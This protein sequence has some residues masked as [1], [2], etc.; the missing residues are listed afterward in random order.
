MLI[1]IVTIEHLQAQ[2]CSC[3]HYRN[4]RHLEK[5]LRST[6]NYVSLSISTL[7]QDLDDEDDSA[8]SSHLGDLNGD[9]SNSDDES[10][11]D[12]KNAPDVWEDVVIEDA[13]PD[14]IPAELGLPAFVDYPHG[15]GFP[16]NVDDMHV[17]PN[18]Q[19][20]ETLYNNTQLSTFH[21]TFAPDNIINKFI[22]ATNAHGAFRSPVTWKEIDVKEFHAFL[23]CIIYLGIFKY[24][25][26]KLLAW[27]TDQGSAVLRALMP[28]TM[29][30]QILSNW[31][32]K[33]FTMLSKAQ[34]NQLIPEDPFWAVTDFSEDINESF[35]SNWNPAQCLDIDEQC[36]PWKGRHKCRCFSPKKPEKW[37]FK[38]YA[39]NCS[40]SGYIVHFKIYRGKGE[41][42]PEGVS[43]TAYPIHALLEPPKFHHRGHVL[44]TD[45]C[46]TSL[47]SVKICGERG[48]HSVDTIKANRKGLPLV[49]KKVSGVRT[50]KMVRGETRTR[51][52]TSGGRELF[53]TIWQAASLFDYCNQPQLQVVSL[54]LI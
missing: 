36:C 15:Y 41:V 38:M 39:L 34:M 17:D 25:T 2:R 45:N 53:Y 13:P 49:P 27:S 12:W 7:I 18:V 51:T 20:S 33:D 6:A 28:R 4:E 3:S 11:G 48:I 32:Y 54:Y 43:A 14:T 23:G 16:A 5:R 24:P 9:Q 37:H 50:A 21:Q 44:F 35:G 10:D 30:E 42:R 8:K 47:Q 46:Y 52:A 19:I 29:F 31:Q 26:R 1:I 40:K 22:T